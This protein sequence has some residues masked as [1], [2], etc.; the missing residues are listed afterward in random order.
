[1]TYIS[2]PR[3]PN[4]SLRFALICD[5]AIKKNKKE[6]TFC[7]QWSGIKHSNLTTLNKM[8]LLYKF[9]FLYGNISKKT[10]V[11]FK[12]MYTQVNV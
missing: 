3:A 6:H 7:W 9:D 11:I 10:P 1:M 2:K 8:V 5:G 4:I 12:H